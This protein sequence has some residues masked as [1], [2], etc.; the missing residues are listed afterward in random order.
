[1]PIGRVLDQLATRRNQADSQLSVSRPVATDLR[2]QDASLDALA[3]I[4]HM[5]DIDIDLVRK[6][7]VIAALP[8][9][10]AV[11]LPPNTGLP[12]ALLP[13]RKQRMRPQHLHVIRP[14]ERPWIGH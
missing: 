10:L 6:V 7:A 11:R 12:R 2:A 14:L 5:D 13:C 4:A 3:M 1:M 8:A 9:D